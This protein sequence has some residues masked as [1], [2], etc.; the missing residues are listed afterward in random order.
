MIEFEQICKRYGEV[1]AVTDLT[2]QVRD[3]EIVV[4]SG[5]SGCGK[6]TT[7]KMINRLIEPTSGTVRIDGR[8]TRQQD[9]NTL[10][11]SIGYVIQH[12][13]LFPHQTVAENIATVPRLLGWSRVKTRSR[14]EELLELVDLP[15]GDFSGRLPAQL[16]GGQRQRVGVARALA[17]D[18]PILLM[19][20]PF[21]AI[22]PVARAGLQDELLRL[23]TIVRKTMVVVTHDIDE[24]LKLADRILVFE[25]GG[26]IAQY[27]TPV[28]LLARPASPFV[29]TFLGAGRS[30]RRLALV[31]LR[32]V[33]LAPLDSEAPAARV[34]IEG[35]LRD[36][37]EA[38]LRSTDG[39]L[40]VHDQGRV[41]GLL[42]M[43]TIR[44]GIQ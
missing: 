43:D 31:P 32:D 34:S 41:A 18:P 13:G 9:V 10:R 21:G 20:E 38:L 1:T 23:Q 29:E 33:C 30:V 5:P 11:R 28:E 3:A 36:A 12:V 24:A 16:S 39:R 26:R 44:R 14:V 2:F 22:D 25:C 19:D 7:L 4:L 6:T 8:D 37:L 35:T 15:P 27:A 17:A 40:T 42:D